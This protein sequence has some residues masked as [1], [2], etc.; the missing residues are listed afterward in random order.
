MKLFTINDN[1]LPLIKLFAVIIINGKLLMV[2]NFIN[3]KC[4]Y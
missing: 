1:Y 4:F 3:A 2:N